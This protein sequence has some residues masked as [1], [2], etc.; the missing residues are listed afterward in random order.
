MNLTTEAEHKAA[1]QEFR[2]LA[3]DEEANRTRLLGL[4]DAIQAFEETSGHNP[5]PPTT[6][7]SRLQVQLFKRHLKQE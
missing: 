7:A 2:V 1:V 5:G 6:V 4:R 3:T